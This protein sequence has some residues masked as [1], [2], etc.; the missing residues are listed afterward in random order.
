MKERILQLTQLAEIS[1]HG[2][3][4]YMYDSLDG[5]LKNAISYILTGY[6]QGN[7]LLLIDNDERYNLIVHRLKEILQSDDMSFLH[8]VNNAEFY[9][10]HGDF[11]CDS[12][13]RHFNRLLA[14]FFEE[15][16]PIRT[17]AH[18]EW[19]EKDV[20]HLELEH[21]EYVSDQN[22]EKSGIISVCAYDGQYVTASL[23]NKLQRSHEYLMTDTELVKST[24]YKMDG[25]VYPSL[26]VQEIDNKT[27]NKLKATKHQLQ[28]FITNNLDPVIIYDHS[29]RV[30]SVNLAFEKTFGWSRESILGLNATELPILPEDRKFEFYRNRSF[31]LRG[32]KIVEYETVR[33]TKDGHLIHVLVSCFPLLNAEN[34]NDG[35]AVIIKDISEKKQAQELLI[36]SEQLSIAGELAAGI[37]HEIRNPITSIKGFFQLLQSDTI[38][39][40]TYYDIILS[41]IERIETILS[42]LL[43]LAKPQEMNLV[44]IN[45]CMLLNDVIVLMDAQANMNSVLMI[46]EFETEEIYIKCEENQ[47]K[48]VC[49]NFIKNAIEAMANGGKL[50]IRLEKKGNEKVLISFIDDGCGIPSNVLE[51]LG[52]PFYTTKEKGTGL[53]FMVSKKIIENHKGTVTIESEENKGTK[54][55]LTLPL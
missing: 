34:Y 38:K 22:I 50:V 16:I 11:H 42:E 5:Y 55:E 2:H 15:G 49:I 47:I 7:Q 44:S 18:V 41:E 28:S 37:A 53:G 54:I 3:I 19:R 21:Y 33:N 1:N 40:N 24:L 10:L 29:D 17:W 52:Q 6:K 12:I 26:S 27:A 46:T 8:Y 35:W 48:Q 36:R 25:M 43:L 23:Q 45:L 31:T 51:K 13:I 30:I 32:E 4:L 14:P 20:D 39:N 9:R